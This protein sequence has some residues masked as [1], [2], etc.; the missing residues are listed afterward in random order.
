MTETL[1]FNLKNLILCVCVWEGERERKGG[2]K[3]MRVISEW[4]LWIGNFSPLKQKKNKF[5]MW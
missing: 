2:R 1:S 5:L 3:G 4:L